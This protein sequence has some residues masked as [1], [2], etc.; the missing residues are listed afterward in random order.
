MKIWPGW[1]LRGLL[2]TCWTTSVRFMFPWTCRLTPTACLTPL[3]LD[4]CTLQHKAHCC[5]DS[6]LQK[7]NWLSRKKHI[8]FCPKGNHSEH[9]RNLITGQR[10]PEFLSALPTELHVRSRSLSCQL[11]HAESVWSLI[12]F[13]CKRWGWSLEY[14]LTAGELCLLLPTR[15]IP[16]QPRISRSVTWCIFWTTSQSL[17][18]FFDSKRWNR[19][20]VEASDRGTHFLYTY[21]CYSELWSFK[22]HWSK[23][24]IRSRQSEVL[25]YRRF[26][27]W[28]SRR[29]SA[30]HLES[31]LWKTFRFKQLPA[32]IQT[33]CSCW[34][35]FK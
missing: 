21:F 16:Q 24:L 23:T 20:N 35:K 8:C 17:Q 13:V 29:A 18:T 27:L 3:T 30:L 6:E 12:V 34:E 25:P 7:Y 9:K 2:V 32:N 4:V 33:F 10:C 19:E 31:S 15:S 11:S 14:S 1:R 28:V 5:C 26:L 22:I